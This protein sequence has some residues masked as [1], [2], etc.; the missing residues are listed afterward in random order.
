[1]FGRVA[2]EGL[3]EAGVG[4]SGVWHDDLEAAG[5]GEGAFD[6]DAGCASL[7]GLANEGVAVVSRSAEGDEDVAGVEAAAIGGAAGDLEIGAAEESCFGEKPSQA[8]GR[9]SPLGQ[10]ID[11]PACHWRSPP[12]QPNISGIHSMNSPVA[13]R[14]PLIEAHPGPPGS[15]SGGIFG[16]LREKGNARLPRCR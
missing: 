2:G 3:A 9:N 5:L 13:S 7:D 15:R 4:G 1:M 14:R 16:Q 6:D 12:C 10:S 11:K 8:D